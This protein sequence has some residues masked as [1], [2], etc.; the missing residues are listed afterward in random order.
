MMFKSLLDR[1][2][3]NNENESIV[4]MWPW[5]D[6]I[7]LIAGKCMFLLSNVYLYFY[8]SYNNSVSFS[9]NSI[10]VCLSDEKAK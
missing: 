1:Q 2:P 6:K 9:K 4:N 8:V 10:N 5:S 3:Q 7:G